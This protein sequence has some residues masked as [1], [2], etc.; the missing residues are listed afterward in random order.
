MDVA[1]LGR[2]TLSAAAAASGRMTCRPVV[3]DDDVGRFGRTAEG[4]LITRFTEHYTYVS[5]QSRDGYQ[6]RGG[7]MLP[8]ARRG[9]T[10]AVKAPGSSGSCTTYANP[11]AVCIYARLILDLRRGAARRQSPKNRPIDSSRGH[12]R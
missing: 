11:R 2:G 7:D 1:P 5:S 4:G 8:R 6:F 12:R 3:T 10:R 9:I